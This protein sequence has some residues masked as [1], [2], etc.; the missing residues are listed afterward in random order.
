M[1]DL[2]EQRRE[3]IRFLSKPWQRFFNRFEEIE[4]LKVSQ[5]KPIHL[6]GYFDKRYREHYNKN[7]AYSCKKAPM[8]CTEIVLIK[9]MCAMLATTNMRT[10]KD[11]IDWVFD[12]KIIPQK[13]KIRTLAFFGTPGLGNEFYEY[14][15]E[16]D[17]IKRTTDLPKKFKDIG[18]KL[19]FPINT[20][21]DLAFAKMA[22]DK[23]DNDEIRAP[24]KALFDQLYSVGFEF[25][26]IKDLK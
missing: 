9:K 3:A 8:K 14:K 5:W 13:M 23:Y 17:K 7:F 21:G 1:I 11:Y 24:Y 2:N 6:L 26:M 4:S 22:L 20:F 19:G 15:S 16:H 10:V 25:E 12:C 18:N